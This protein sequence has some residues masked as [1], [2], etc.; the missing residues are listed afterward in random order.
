M[1]SSSFTARID[2]SHVGLS[3]DLTEPF[4]VLAEPEFTDSVSEIQP[5][6]AWS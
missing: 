4:H 2:P 3:N 6:S 5:L 1:L